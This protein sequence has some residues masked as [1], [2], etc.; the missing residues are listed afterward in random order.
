M[1]HLISLG[2]L[3]LITAGPAF[4]QSAETAPLTI[5]IVGLRN[6]EGSVVVAAFDQAEAFENIDIER[7]VALAVLPASSERVSVTLHTLPSRSFAVAVLHDEDNDNELG[8]D[9]KMPTEGYSF[10]AMGPSGLPP[11]FNDAAISAALDA[12]V[13]LRLKYW[14]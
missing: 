1:K 5:D 6:A 11:R 14:R 3:A 2:T 12:R 13:T 7:A 8:M 10:A 4:A 9:G